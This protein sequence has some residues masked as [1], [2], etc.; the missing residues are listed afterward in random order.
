ME[1]GGTERVTAAPSVADVEVEVR[2][3]LK[4]ELKLELYAV[5][6]YTNARK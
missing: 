3:K 2:P 1:F 5:S 4:M 6:R